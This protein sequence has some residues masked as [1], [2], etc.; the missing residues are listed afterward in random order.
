MGVALLSMVDLYMTLT[1]VMGAG[2]VEGNPLARGIMA[3]NSPALLAAWKI[4][5]V[6]LA[7]GILIHARK[8]RTGEIAAW[9]CC[10][11]LVWLTVR[12]VDYNAQIQALTPYLA[13]I[14]EQENTRWVAIDPDS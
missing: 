11:V 2:M 7:I 14:S 6:G 4:S 8:R 3:Y 5:T 1:H 9:I 10:G 13:S 12:W